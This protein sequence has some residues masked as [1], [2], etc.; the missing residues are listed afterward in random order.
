MRQIRYLLLGIMLVLVG[1]A[2][3]KSTTI[4]PAPTTSIPITPTLRFTMLPTWTPANTPIPV[5]T[6]TPRNTSTPLV[7]METIPFIRGDFTKELLVDR[8]VNA[9]E[10]KPA[11]LVT[12]QYNPTVWNLNTSYPANYMGYS[13]TNRSIY[14]CNLG[15]TFVASA[16][17]YEVEQYNR[18]FGSTKFEISRFSQAGM[19]QFSNYCTGEGENSTCYQMTPGDDHTACSE[20][21][22]EVL[23]SYKLIANPFY[24]STAKPSNRWACE[25]AS[26]TVGLC[27][28]SYS[29]PMNALT[30]TPDGQAWAAGD[31]GRLLHRE[32]QLWNEFKSPATHP[33]YDIRFSSAT[34]GWAVGDGAEVLHWDGSQW[35]EV[36]PYHGPG[37]GPGGSTQVLYSVD[38]QSPNEAWMAGVMKE[39]DGK[40]RPYALHWTGKD[41]IEENEFPE[42]NCGINTIHIRTINDVFAAGGSD[43]GAIIFHWD[44][45][46]WTSEQLVGAD[47]LYM[48]S[49]AIDGSIW[50]GGIEVA[51]DQSDTRGALF[52][53]DGSQWFRV[54]VPPLTGG[55]YALSAL[56]SEKIVVGGDFTA[57]RSGLEWQAIST[58]IAGYQ[59]I[60]DIEQDPRGNVWALTRSGNIFQLVTQ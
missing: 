10:A 55:I 5:A 38:V 44:G 16:E 2:Q 11:N 7:P 56:S 25:D 3:T 31:D 34:D 24:G 1:C 22:E 42:C 59:W 35:S 9:Q 13:L 6:R 17:G 21:A 48:L 18:S 47:H 43:L 50:A 28:V 36:L 8:P 40:I 58:D 51:R 23:S 53:W 41:L 12:L 33:L 37:E 26:G 29:V 54:S 30:F 60:M 19:L 39:I 27:A 46:T 45:S 32:G 14:G 49:Q 52:H 15:Q 57:L 4:T 20:A